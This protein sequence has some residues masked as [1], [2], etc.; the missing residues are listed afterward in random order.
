[1]AAR[2]SRLAPAGV[3]EQARRA[4][5]RRRTARSPPSGHQFGLHCARG[6]PSRGSARAAPGVVLRWSEIESGA[7]AAISVTVDVPGANPRSTAAAPTGCVSSSSAMQTPRACPG[8]PSVA[9]SR[10][11]GA[12]PPVSVTSR[13]SARPMV[14]LARQPGPSAPM[15]EC[16]PSASRTGPLTTTSWPGGEVVTA[17]PLRLKA[18]SSAAST[19][20]EH[21]RE[22]RGAAAGEHRAGRHALERRLAHAGRHRAERCAAGRGPPSI[23]ATRSGVGGT[24]GRPSV[25]P[26]SNRSSCSS[27][28][29]PLAAASSAIVAASYVDFAAQPG[30][31]RRLVRRERAPS[32]RRAPAACAS[33]PFQRVDVPADDATGLAA[34]ARRR[35]PRSARSRGRRRASVVRRRLGQHL[36]V[37]ARARARCGRRP[38]QRVLEHGRQRDAVPRSGP[39]RRPPGGAG[40]A[41]DVGHSSAPKTSRTGPPA[42]SCS[43][44]T[45]PPAVLSSANSGARLRGARTPISPTP[46]RPCGR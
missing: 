21:D 6:A 34:V 22:V 44:P 11:P 12:P 16:R 2:T 20:R 25:Q 23:A 14:R 40:R 10:P 39:A 7:S 45:G 15:P 31:L 29:D 30:L 8:G 18:S 43:S 38:R 35:G 13:R 3:G 19:R 27:S 17:W 36:A 24:T 46:A 41:R 4:R 37:E 28:A 26:R 5:G 33:R 9:R 42:R 1:M 32:R